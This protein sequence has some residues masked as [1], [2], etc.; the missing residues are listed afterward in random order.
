M[1]TDIINMDDLDCLKLD[2]YLI[3]Y[4]IPTDSAYV[5]TGCLIIIVLITVR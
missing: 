1:C 2:I 3:Y 5:Y 4:I